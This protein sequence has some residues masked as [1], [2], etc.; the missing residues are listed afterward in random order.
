M[1]KIRNC[2]EEQLESWR[3]SRIGS[4]Y[5]N[6]YRLISENPDAEKELQKVEKIMKKR[7][8][9]ENVELLLEIERQQTQ[10]IFSEYYENAKVVNDMARRFYNNVLSESLK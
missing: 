10:S 2:S 3:P 4:Y 8:L 1:I 6:N 5:M 9:E 7:P